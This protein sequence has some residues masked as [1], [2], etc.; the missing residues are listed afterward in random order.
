MEKS[1]FLYGALGFLALGLAS[2]SSDDLVMNEVKAETDLSQFIAVQI[3]APRDVASRAFEDGTANESYVS[4]LDFLFYD[5]SGRPTSEPRT[6]TEFDGEGFVEDSE[7]DNI[8]RMYT[9]VVPVNL[10]QGQNL[11]S[12]VICIVNGIADAVN[13][14][15]TKNLSE[16]ID[17]KR[18]YFRNVSSFVMSNSVYYGQNVLTGQA[19][20]RLC[21]TP[22]NVNTQL[23]G[24]EDEAK[25]AI[26]NQKDG[27]IVDIYV[28]RLAAKV[29]LTMGA[30][31]STAYQ[32]VNGDATGENINITFVPEYWAMNAT[33]DENYLTKRYGIEAED[34]VINLSPTYTQI[35][36]ALGGAGWSTWNAP[37]FY[38]SYWGC[39]PSYF[40]SEYPAVSDDVDDLEE[41]THDYPVTYYSY[42]G[43]K[44][45][46]NRT[47]DGGIGK[48][49]LAATDGAFSITNTGNAATGFIYTRE[50]TTASRIIRD[51]QEFNPAAAVASAV[52]VGQYTVEGS[53]A[54]KTFYVDRNAGVIDGKTVGRYYGSMETARAALAAR[55]RIVYTN[56][57]GTGVAAGDIF[58]LAHPKH[59][60]RQQAGTKLAGRLVT[61]Q[62]EQLPAAPIYY[63]NLNAETGEGEYKQVETEQDILN[64]NAQLLSVGYLDMFA[65][66]HAFFSVPVRHLN[67][68]DALYTNGVYDWANMPV[69]ALG[70][71]RNHVYNL[72]VSK[73]SGLGTG[74]RSDDQPIVP[75]K[76]E[77]NQYIAAR[78]NILS[79]NVANTWSVEL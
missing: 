48:Q 36:T 49:A 17:V 5:A 37:E 75:A 74:L 73:I 47:D 9:T 1:K 27:A 63:Y 59:A 19:N 44:A 57:N 7:H 70:I 16:V 69:G 40:D 72:T 78:I 43:V 14:L 12:Q 41:Y 10:V 79:W 77:A 51:S 25:T 39:S 46:A 13:E 31:A 68:K 4:R 76:E 42:N 52:I 56:V 11:P 50:T 28:E 60:V 61:L 3:S 15:K 18:N 22:I 54:P 29:G 38:R 67:W 33:A 65:N 20:Q 64:V 24:T 26:T 62:L 2:C 34:G 45:Q 30:D 8:T 6:M 23:F 53:D 66:G 32:L 21:A 35:S 58:A 55:Q 71:I